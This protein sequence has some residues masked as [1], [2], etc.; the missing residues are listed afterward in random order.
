MAN[1]EKII[2]AARGKAK[3]DVVLRNARVINVYSGEVIPG[4]VAILGDRIVGIGSYRGAREFDLKGK[5]VAPGFIDSHVHLE[6][7][8]VTVPEFAKVVVPL[9]TTSVISDPHELANVMGLDGI[10]Y[11]L[12]SSKYNP[13]NVFIM[14]PSCVPSSSLETSGAELRA[15]D[16]FFFLN[17][18]W[19][20]GLAEV[21]D[22]PGLLEGDPGIL[23]KIKIAGRKIIDGHAP[24]LTGRDLC[25]YLAVG[26][27]SDHECSTREEALEKLRHGMTI[28][29]REGGLARNMEALLP[30]VT[31][32]NLRQ[33]TFCTDDRHPQCL[34]EDGHMNAVIKKAIRLG[35]DP[36]T[37][38]R[39]CTINPAEHYRLEELG[40]VA[41]GK[42]ADLV[43][44]DNFKN[45]N[46]EMVF[47]N[48]ELAAKNG[49]LLPQVISSM[50]PS[51][52]LRGSINIQ[53]LKPD[54][55]Q[56]QAKKG[57]CRVIGLVPGQLI[58]REELHKPRVVRGRVVTDTDRD[59]LKLVVVERH[60][61]SPNIGIGLVR[62]F[63]LKK[64]AIASS[65]AHDAHN[66]IAV[67]TNDADIMEAVIK[68]R[69][70]QGGF[71]AVVDKKLVG[72]LALPVAGLISMKPVHEVKDELNELITV[73]KEM[74]CSLDDPFMA[75]SFLALPVIPDIKLTDKGL[76]DVN[77][78]KIIPLFTQNKA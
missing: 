34:V 1:L 5:F 36:L 68:I 75:L 24:G 10:N 57:R 26:I 58:T 52:A 19:V 44:I 78:Q 77:S 61:A 73:A 21:M 18:E 11:M 13:L 76:V 51:E 9:G 74:G 25:A 30:L 70:F 56:I 29:I 12:R 46:V 69:K 33:F 41:P 39:M 37:A 71:T 54:Y 63:G 28:M 50:R 20:L 66:I 35:M 72:S 6:S 15:T 27:S 14:I 42:I 40:A 16:I 8:M 23:D 65:V 48:G 49:R 32:Q 60:H 31:P 43:V 2:K 67:G 22:Y 64:G 59:L 38:I 47:K 7:S 55:F 17:Q 53:W 4:D 62:G 45:F 3:S